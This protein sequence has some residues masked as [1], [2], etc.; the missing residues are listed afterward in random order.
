MLGLPGCRKPLP[1]TPVTP[2]ATP[3]E[4]ALVSRS[5]ANHSHMTR[6]YQNNHEETISSFHFLFVFLY[7]IF[8]VKDKKKAC[9]EHV[10]VGKEKRGKQVQVMPFHLVNITITR[11]AR[12]PTSMEVAQAHG[13]KKKR[14]P[15]EVNESMKSSDINEWRLI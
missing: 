9:P 12:T 11:F 2:H 4:G 3:T 1:V 5:V 10:R 14:F 7:G 6:T 13:I 8:P 15:E